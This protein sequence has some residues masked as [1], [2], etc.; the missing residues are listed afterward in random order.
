L[1]IL[2]EESDIAEAMTVETIVEA[3]CEVRD[4]VHFYHFLFSISIFRKASAMVELR[5][6]TLHDVPSRP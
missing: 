6:K 4:L 1:G 2:K 3:E 5:C